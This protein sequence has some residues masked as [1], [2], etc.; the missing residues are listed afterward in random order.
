MSYPPSERTSVV[1]SISLETTRDQYSSTSRLQPEHVTGDEEAHPSESDSVSSVDA[2][3][4]GSSAAPI[5]AEGK[6]SG[7]IAWWWW[8]IGAS[9]ISISFSVLLM[10]FLALVDGK[11]RASWW[12]YLE[13]STIISICTTIIKTTLMVP[14]SACLSQLKWLH[15]REDSYPLSHLERIDNASRGPGGALDILT[16]HPV[17]NATILALALVN[18]VTLILEPSAQQLLQIENR[19]VNVT[20]AAG[21]MNQTAEIGIATSYVSKSLIGSECLSAMIIIVATY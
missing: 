14:V 18:V 10:L 6:A 19:T 7:S 1:S 13:P 12:F 11:P 9:M 17:R 4:N 16:C 8:E 21:V 2:P 20:G 5:P 15:F 3:T